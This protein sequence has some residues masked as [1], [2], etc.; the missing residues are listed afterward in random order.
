VLFRSKELTALPDLSSKPARVAIIFDYASQWAWEVQPQDV[1]FDY[2]RLVY[3]IY[4]GL[5]RIGL[6]IDILPPNADDFGNYEQVFIPGLFAWTEGLRTAIDGFTGEVV[7]GPR[8]GSRTD[9]FKLPT[10]LP[11]GFPGLKVTAV[12]TL[13]EDSPVALP[14]GGAVQIWR[15]RMESDWD[16]VE[17]DGDGRP[18]RLVRGQLT[19]GAGWPDA[20]ALDRWLGG[21]P[22]DARYRDTKGGI[23]SIDYLNATF[24]V[25]P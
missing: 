8:T 22:S 21:E 19:Y 16:V 14:A 24:S 20:A 7:I 1:Q 18:V 5:R 11:P 13:R 17:A 10:T 25:L 9:D 15:E 4:C 6:S 2:F 23:T 12:E 3:E